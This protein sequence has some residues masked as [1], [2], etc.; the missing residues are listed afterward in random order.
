MIDTSP[1][2]TDVTLVIAAEPTMISVARTTAASL[3]AEADFVLDDID[4]V[5]IAVNELVTLLIE[6]EPVENR[7]HLVF[8][9][10]RQ[11]DDTTTFSMIATTAGGRRPIAAAELTEQIL[12]A[13]ADEVTIGDDGCRLR[14]NESRPLG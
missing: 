1:S 13:V 12:R 2:Q 10:E 4:N 5:R 9:L 3:V 8:A 14:I 11:P 6:T 7:I